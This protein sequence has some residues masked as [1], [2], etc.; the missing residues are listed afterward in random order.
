MKQLKLPERTYYLHKSRIYE[1]DKKLWEEHARDSLESRAL[2][3]MRSLDQ[4]IQVNTEI[5]LDKQQDPKARIDAS[6]KVV[7]VNIMAYNIL[8]KGPKPQVVTS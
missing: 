2:K 1:Q 8:R 5:A 3:I 4:C 6:V 7:D